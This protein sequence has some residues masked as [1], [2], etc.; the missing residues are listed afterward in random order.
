MNETAQGRCYGI[1]INALMVIYPYHM[2]LYRYMTHEYYNIF[3][4]D[5]NTIVLLSG[6]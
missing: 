3:W 5:M 2:S 4:G 1:M 6:I